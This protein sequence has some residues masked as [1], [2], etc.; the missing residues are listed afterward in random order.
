MDTNMKK[1]YCV[2]CGTEVPGKFCPNCGTPVNAT[3]QPAPQPQV[4]APIIHENATVKGRYNAGVLFLAAYL[5]IVFLIM[6]VAFFVGM[7]V[8]F[9]DILQNNELFSFIGT[10]LLC[11]GM[12]FLCYLPGIRMI[13]KRSPKGTVSKTLVSFV[14]KS[15]WFP[16]AWAITIMG[17]SFLVGIILRVWRVGLSASRPKDTEYT[18]FVDGEKI[19]VTRLIDTEYSTFDKIRY[20]YVDQNGEFYRPSLY[21]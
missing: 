1:T 4:D 7:L 18:A 9:S 10:L 2:N 21:K 11:L 13:C 6:F 14:F 19:A 16:F 8:N 5:G 20:I 3:L 15:I 17:C 12:L